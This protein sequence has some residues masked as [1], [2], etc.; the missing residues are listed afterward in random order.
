MEEVRSQL[1]QASKED[2][3][4][5]VLAWADAELP[6]KREDFLNKLELESPDEIS[7]TDA[8]TLLEEIEEFTEE[9]EDGVYVDGY[10]WDHDLMEERDFGDES[11]AEEMDHFFLEAREL[12]RGGNNQAAEKVYRKLFAI[13][14]LR[15][16]PGYLPGDLDDN[17]MLETDLHEHTALFLRSVYMNADSDE[18]AHQLYE[19]MKEYGY[20]TSPRMKLAD[21]RDALDE[22][23]PDFDDF[24]ADWIAFLK[25]KSL[26]HVNKLLR[27]AVFLK[28]GIPAIADFAKNYADKL[29]EAYLDWITALEKKGERESV[30]GVITEGLEKISGNFTARADIAEKLTAIAEEQNDSE[31]KLKGLRESFYSNPSLNYL[32][33][34]YILAK[35]ENCLDEVRMEAENRM[36]ALRG[37]GNA[38]GYGRFASIDEGDYIHALLLGGKYE[39]VFDLCQ[40]KGPLGWSSSA[41]PKPAM[42]LFLMD[43]LSKGGSD[44]KVFQDQKRYA[45][46]P[47]GFGMQEKIMEKYNKIMNWVRDEIRLTGEQEEFYLE[48]CQN[49]TGKRIDAVVSNKYRGSYD[50]AAKILVVMAETLAIRKDKQAGHAFAEK[51]R[52]KYARFPAFQKEVKK[53][54]GNSVL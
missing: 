22:S 40:G 20:L 13:L 23:L 4:R 50:K 8:D 12:L 30:L 37:D 3:Q 28:G 11:W 16:E 36:E 48:W 18:R 47:G 2:L 52:S 25:E 21:I 27:E 45:V 9:V 34:L 26:L 54:L 10:G 39:K 19:N 43:V 51:Y 44:S 7:G 1:E 14:E 24:L 33:D 6:D 17:N 38:L 35:K 46:S 29:P 41:H 49:E 53:A 42:L 15:E 5:L 31:M 32:L